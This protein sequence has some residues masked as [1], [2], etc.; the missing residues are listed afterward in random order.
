MLEEIRTVNHIITMKMNYLKN[1]LR[2]L[3]FLIITLLTSTGC[4]KKQASK[5]N[6]VFV[7]SDQQSWDML[8]CYGNKRVISPNLDKLASEGI[9][10]NHCITSS[11]VCSPYRGM[12][13]SGQHPLVN[14]TIHNDIRMLPGEGKYFG[15]ILR[16]NGYRTGYYG[17]WHLYGGDRVRPVP[18]GPYRYGFDEEFLTNNCTL[19]Y[20]KEKSYYWD[21]NN[22]KQL[23]GEW[24]PDGQT[25]QAVTFIDNHAGEPFALFLSWHPPHNWHTPTGWDTT[26]GYKYGWHKKGGYKYGAPGE[27][28][29]MYDPGSI[30]L[31]P[32]AADNDSVRYIYQGH[33]AMIT[34]LDRNFG[35]IIRKLEEKGI[36]D[37]SI[38][39]FTADHGDLLASHNWPNNKACP[40]IESIR[41]PLIVKWAGNLKPR[42]SELLVGTLDLM[43]TILGL[44]ALPVPGTCQGIDLSK[45]IKKGND[46]MVKS[47]PLFFF[48]G[49]WRGIYTR[50]YTYAFTLD[51][52]SPEPHAITAGWLN[53]NVLYSHKDDPFELNNLF[54]NPDY[55][56]VKETLHKKSLQW[57][58]KFRDDSFIFKETIQKILGT[59]DS[60]AYTGG[61]PKNF[62]GALLGRPIEL[63]K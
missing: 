36:A 25:R 51:G 59:D 50:D 55:K 3:S 53:Q 22:E 62:E 27:F 9:R 41:V 19:D 7:L 38:I 8:G 58:K 39:I 11:P 26:E 35:L 48:P 40:E 61:K 5:P 18:R 2:Y 47:V 63:L 30:R 43:P 31:R 16:D 14:G 57:M 33:M 24:E 46:E 29:N 37:N 23:Y 45:A 13:L 52:G 12:L 6:L 54:L 20:S 49:D 10:F 28:V 60:K 1:D 15:E 42:V 21:E 4:H 34:N 32:N 17:K 44:M 56:N